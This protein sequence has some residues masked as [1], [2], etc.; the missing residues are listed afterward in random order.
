MTS[1]RKN[2]INTWVDKN[3]KDW[4][5][6]M[7][8]KKVLCGEKI[9]NLGQITEEILNLPALKELENQLIKNKTKELVK[10]QMDMRRR[11]FL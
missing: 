3:F 5:E 8:A 7:K 10:L 11:K 4:L 1:K 9:D 6:K 2:Q